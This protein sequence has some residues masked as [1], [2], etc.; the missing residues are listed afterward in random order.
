MKKLLFLAIV[1]LLMLNS[2]SS[3]DDSPNSNEPQVVN[4][5]FEVTTSRNSEAIIT[6]TINNDTETDN[7]NNLPYSRTYAQ[8][9]VDSGTFLELTYLE[10]GSYAASSGGGSS[11]TDYTATL[12]ISV[13]NTVVSTQTFD[14]TETTTGIRRIDFTFE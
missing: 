6:T 5:T 13:N 8:T 14:I 10:N 12:N 4:I 2:C 3:D 7:A 9:E 1:C 11:W